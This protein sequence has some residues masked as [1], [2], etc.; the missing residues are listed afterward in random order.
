M[1]KISIL[2]VIFIGSCYSVKNKELEGK[3]ICDGENMEA[4]FIPESEEEE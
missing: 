2:F 4:I 3:V 1:K